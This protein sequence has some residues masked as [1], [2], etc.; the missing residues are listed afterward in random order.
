MVG[1]WWAKLRRG[2]SIKIETWGLRAA[3]ATE[4][5]WKSLDQ[6]LN[7]RRAGALGSTASGVGNPTI[8]YGKVGEGENDPS[9]GRGNQEKR[10][11]DKE[12]QWEVP[13]DQ[14][15]TPKPNPPTFPLRESRA[16]TQKITDEDNKRRWEKLQEEAANQYYRSEN[17]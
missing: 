6:A 15:S 4:M 17:Q 10:N 12:N 1:W 11:E 14:K 3:L 2:D 16:E 7:W 13:K 9:P 8:E 5:A